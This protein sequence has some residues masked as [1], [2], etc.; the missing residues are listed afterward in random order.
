MA[1]KQEQVS[2]AGSP[3]NTTEHW[4]ASGVSRA[5]GLL[6]NGNVVDSFKNQLHS[7]AISEA[8][9]VVQNWLQRY[10]TIKLQANVDDRGRLEGSQFDM[11][12]PLYDI[13]KQMA[14]TQ[15]GLR[16]I[17]SRT[18]ANFGLGQRHF[19][20]TSLLGYN[21]FL[22]HDITRDHTRIG[23]GAEYARDFMKFGANGYFRAS[24]WKEGKKLQD[25]DERP[26]NGFDLRAEGYMPTYPQLGGKLVYEQYFG[27]EVGLLSEE[28]RQKNPAV[29]TLGASY[30][31]IP[32]V[33]LGID[34]KQS[35]QGHG[36]TLFNF[37]LSYE[38]GTPWSE[39][40]NP[41]VVAFKRSLQG[42]RYDLVERNNQIVL[43]HRKKDLVHLTIENRIS[44]RGNEIMPL[45]VTI[46]SK[47]GLKEIIW[48]TA[49][50]EAGGGQLEKVA[51]SIRG[52]THYRLTLPPYH[53]KGN[54]T[55]I[56]S[57]IAYDNEGNASE[58]AETQVRVLSSEIAIDHSGFEV[59]HTAM[60]ADGKTQTALWLK[61]LDKDGNVVRGASDSI[62][63]FS[64][65]KGLKGQG[66][67]P[68]LDSKPKETPENSGIYK[69]LVTS[70]EKYGKWEIQAA[71]DGHE[72]SPAVIDFS[73][74][75][76][77]IAD[78][79]KSQ[80]RVSKEGALDPDESVTFG[81][82]LFDKNG[83]VI[84]GAEDYLKLELNDSGLYSQGKKPSVG[85]VKELPSGSGQYEWSVKGDGTKGQ[86]GVTISVEGRAIKTINV[87]FGNT[88]ADTV[89][90]AYSKISV[91]VTQLEVDENHKQQ[92]TLRLELKDAQN[93]PITGVQQHIHFSGTGL[94]GPGSEPTIGK[95]QE[96]PN[97]PGTYT[98]TLT[99]GTQT[100]EWTIMLDIDGKTLNQIVGRITFASLLADSVNDK[101]ST[102]TINPRTLEAGTGKLAHI[103]LMLKDKDGQPMTGKA[104]HIAFEGSQLPGSG[105]DPEIVDIREDE[106]NQGTYI[107]T[108]QAGSKS[109]QWKVTLKVDD[110][111]L[112]QIAASINFEPSLADRI[113][114]SKSTFAVATKKLEANN[115]MK[116]EI[117][118]ILK[119][120][121]N[122]PITGAQEYIHFDLSKLSGHGNPPEIGAVQEEEGVPGTYKATLMAGGQAGS[123][124]VTPKVGEKV[125]SSLSDTVEFTPAILPKISKLK[126]QVVTESYPYNEQILMVGRSLK[127]DYEFDSNGSN[128]TDNS[129]YAW[130]KK[131]ETAA[132]V[133]ELA[134]SGDNGNKPDLQGDA[135]STLVK[136]T[137]KD[138]NGVPLYLIREEH[139]GEVL[140]FSILARNGE[141]TRTN[142]IL[143][144]ST[145]EP[146][147]Q[148][149]ETISKIGGGRVSNIAGSVV[150]KLDANGKG[151]TLPI[152]IG[153]K[154]VIKL[155]AKS[156]LAANS[157][158]DTAQLTVS[159]LNKN[160][161]PA[162]WVHVEITLSGEDRKS[163][164]VPDAD[165]K[166]RLAPS[167]GNYATTKYEG[168]T[169]GTGQLVMTVS[170][171]DGKGIQTY[172]RARAD[173]LMGA[174]SDTHSI[175]F[176][177][178]TSP[179][180]DNATYWGHM[181]KTVTA[182][183]KTFHRPQL[184]DEKHLEDKHG[185][186]KNNET[187][188]RM[189]WSTVKEYCKYGNEFNSVLPTIAD[190]K[191][192][193][194]YNL[195]TE[196]LYLYYGWPVK[197][198]NNGYKIWT[199]ETTSK[200]SKE[201]R[202]VVDLDTNTLGDNGS[203]DPDKGEYFIPICLK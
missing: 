21:A 186:E 12:L 160:K 2:S 134:N 57:G 173:T 43:E 128:G 67:N 108:I 148:G 165:V 62:E 152:G 105:T 17:N 122:Q 59:P 29:F 199:S 87:I 171:P 177:V 14:F 19:F 114:E 183:G 91:D 61:L 116:T 92:T 197:N 127:V 47:Y 101:T 159:T 191:G 106:N 131:G 69:V 31:P 15:F 200:G 63:L 94:S 55:Y 137:V 109:G 23:I 42:G 44:G 34:R 176:T 126:L 26:A 96:D 201:R 189:K 49:A 161:T 170:D 174:V 163:K 195:S 85:Q 5:A 146:A 45:N 121:D 188:L 11:L 194:E 70:G 145:D 71:V 16:H 36:E 28:H 167:K 190:A 180:D 156:N 144:R 41:G 149:N 73:A 32:L 37:G 102:L 166:T 157:V 53:D 98:A 86:L 18:T 100:G 162:P 64:D 169:D 124:T 13:E 112:D 140:E 99:A 141:N 123:L 120:N 143:T 192:L 203:D 84:T 103:Q 119:D 48:D 118:L 181:P 135:D 40:V 164:T 24:G 178:I 22:D 136:G 198:G 74:S 187:W 8:N 33:T 104:S 185:Y 142:D 113:N 115:H 129:F 10:G 107:A 38:L 193:A 182:G 88:L 139:A 184:A 35:A 168:Y 1:E 50:L 155:R 66:K 132:A 68:E 58:R 82:T 202:A 4:L 151:E 3:E 25:Y 79:E 54:N 90:D 196:D 80:F 9:Q 76:A 56:L 95:T 75:L 78:V 179:D 117:S 52:G 60:L 125:L 77:E 172:L 46:R 111:K 72:L 39:Q 138:G 133:K 150:I 6:K 147:D 65:L 110:V 20:D 7:M 154:S 97:H 81:L 175:I 158:S 27:H 30:T 130:G 51:P 83:N 89:S 153:G 93:K